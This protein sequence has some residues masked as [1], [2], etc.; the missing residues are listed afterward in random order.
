MPAGARFLNQRLAAA[1]IALRLSDIAHL[2]QDACDRAV[3]AELVS[4]GALLSG[5]FAKLALV[6]IEGSSSDRP[7]LNTALRQAGSAAPSCSR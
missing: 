4:L 5:D 7:R 6:E 1:K 2:D 3:G